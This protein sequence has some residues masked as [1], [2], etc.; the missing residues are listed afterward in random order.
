MQMPDI[1]FNIVVPK[2]I[3]EEYEN[4]SGDNVNVKTEIPE[5]EFIKLMCQSSSCI[6][7]A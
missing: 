1:Q 7:A 3:F 2:T 4:N 6:D 5:P